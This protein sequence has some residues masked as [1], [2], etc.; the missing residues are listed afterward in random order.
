[1]EIIAH[2]GASAAA[3]E[4]TLEAF[5]LAI[6]Q[7]AD[8]LEFDVRL[9]ACGTPVIIHDETLKRTHRLPLRVSEADATQLE[10]LGIPLLASVL[11]RYGPEC[12]LFIEAKTNE[13]AQAAAMQ[14]HLA[15]K[16][17]MEAQKLILISFGHNGLAQVRAE[18]P[19]LFIGAS[20]D[21][22]FSVMDATALP[23]RPQ[24]LAVRSNCITPLTVTEAA[25]AG[26]QLAAW[27]VNRRQEARRLHLLGIE[28]MMTD[29][30]DQAQGWLA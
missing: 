12:R 26:L 24:W 21:A 13:A 2:R 4:N 27:T 11:W 1:M 20:Y 6:A 7:G 8:G 25:Q 17:G 10:A 16:S 28:A 19:H 3:A 18:F 30:P 5:D 22:S 23:C 14:I 29:T 15:L 9:T